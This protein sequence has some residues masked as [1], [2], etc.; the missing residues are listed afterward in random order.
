MAPQRRS[1]LNRQ[2]STP[3]PP[4]ESSV[5]V[6]EEKEE[7]QHSDSG[8]DSD[9]DEQKEPSELDASEDDDDDDDG[10]ESE[11]MDDSESRVEQQ[12]T[13]DPRHGLAA[14]V[15][16]SMFEKEMV[17]LC[18]QLPGFDENIVR[19]KVRSMEEAKLRS[20]AEKWLKQGE[21]ELNILTS[22]MA[23]RA[24]ILRAITDAS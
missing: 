15:A 13:L 10:E 14:R 24:E 6:E 7:Q 2:P 12:P 22:I 19:A 11:E 1:R 16:V 17:I 20:L 8:E 18:G 5:D 21:E 4:V 23:M 3:P 9:Q